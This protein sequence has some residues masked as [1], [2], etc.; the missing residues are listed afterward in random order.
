[1]TRMK[2]AVFKLTFIVLTLAFATAKHEAV[3][4]KP[5]SIECS[6]YECSVEMPTEQVLSKITSRLFSMSSNI[7][8]GFTVFRFRVLIL[9]F[10][11]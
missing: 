3:A 5:S 1:M 6:S 7:F 8:Q 9:S 4:S 2:V 11:F 10:S